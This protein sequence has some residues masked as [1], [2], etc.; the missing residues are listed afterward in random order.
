MKIIKDNLH[1]VWFTSDTH[2]S[3]TNICRGVSKWD[4]HRANNSVRDFD[5]VD[6]MNRAL[7]DNI[8][9]VVMPNDTLIHLGDWSFGGV[10][11]ISKFK[12]QLVCQ[13]ILLVLGN[14]DHHIRRNTYHKYVSQQEYFEWVGDYLEITI[15]DT[16]NPKNYTN[17]TVVCTHY[18]MASW[19]KLGKG[20]I[21][22]HGH[23][24]TPKQF[25]IPK[26]GKMMDVGVDG[27]DLKPWAFDDVK[28]L[29]EKQPIASLLQHYFDH[30]ISADTH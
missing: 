15:V 5:T 25:I 16:T 27:N 24:H 19:D 13:N 6:D 26:A 22:L 4:V 30:H 21:H 1:N 9:K 7:V 17:D 14:H 2:Y 10:E 12:H 20:R 11:Q 3:H 28:R 23:I 29:M 18:P 8:N